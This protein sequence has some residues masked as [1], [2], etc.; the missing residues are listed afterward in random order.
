MAYCL[1]H[2]PTDS[3]SMYHCVSVMEFGSRAPLNTQKLLV[4]GGVK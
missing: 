3:K 1:L 4:K 2:F